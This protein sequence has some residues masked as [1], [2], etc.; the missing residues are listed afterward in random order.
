MAK[1]CTKCGSELVEGKCTKCKETKTEK[2]EVVEAVDVKESFMNALNVFKSIFTK[3]IETV[4]NFVTENNFV[5]GIILIVATALATGLHKIAALKE[6]YSSTNANSLNVDDFSDMFQAAMSGGSF[7]AKPDYLKEFMTTFAYNLVEFAAIALIGYLV[8]TALFK[9]A[10]SIKEMFANVGIALALVLVANLVNSALVFVDGEVVGYIRSYIF[11]FGSIFSYFLLYVG[12]KKT[13]NID[14][15]KLF[16]S[17]ATM[18]ITA[19]M[20]IDI[21]HKI[22]K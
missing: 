16:L 13:S 20:V 5:S 4:E 17:V 10:S 18:C 21:L 11:T 2:V 19:T 6:A 22:F 15:E 12:I 14:K 3:P 7:D 9:G 8:I 1:F